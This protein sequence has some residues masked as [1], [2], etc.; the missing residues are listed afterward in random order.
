MKFTE[1]KNSIESGAQ[2][3]YLF[4]GDDA[5]FRIKGEESVKNAFLEM[6]ELNY[7][8]FDGETLKGS[9]CSSL[10][11][12]IKNYPFMAEKRVVKVSE[13]YPSES[14]FEGYFKDLF[15][16]FPPTTILIIVN[17]GGKKGVDLKRKK[18][19]TYIDCNKP[20]QEAVT[21]WIYLTLRRA[22]ISA[23]PAVCEN[24]CLYCLCNM[25][26]VSVEVQKLI[27]YKGEGTLTQEEVDALVYKDAEYRLYE[28]TNAIPR[29]DFT[30]FTNI[31]DELLKK[32]GDEIYILNGLF[33]Y[34]KN[35]LTVSSSNDSDAELA[36]QLKMKEYGVKKSREQAY[37]IG[38]EKLKFFVKYIYGCISDIKCGKTTPENALQKAQN[39]IFF[40]SLSNN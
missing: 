37:S 20:D 17:S 26:R 19:V 32:G 29:R 4:E 39:A 24:I 9:A 10:V 5:Y 33:N 40:G 12:A 27:D 7:S 30:K 3:I 1:L 23:S 31:L 6:P 11:S 16:D 13:F 15:D 21:K 34:F 8:A 36:T 35:L 25:A 14:D 22:K 38:E 18:A 2:S 28:L